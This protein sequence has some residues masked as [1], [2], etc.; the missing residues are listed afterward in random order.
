MLAWLPTYFSDSLSLNLARAAQVGKRAADAAWERKMLALNRPMPDHQRMITCWCSWQPLGALCLPPANV[1]P[2]AAMH[3]S[4][5]LLSYPLPVQVSLL[6]PVAAIAASALAGPSA[7]ALISRGVPVETVRKAS[8]VCTLCAAAAE[9]SR[10]GTACAAASAPG[11]CPCAGA[12]HVTVRICRLV[13]RC[14][15]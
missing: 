3:C 2:D 10:A 12:W 13:L 14:P 7:D 6:P 11:S 9:V 1:L 5:S 8:Q 4:P 15:C